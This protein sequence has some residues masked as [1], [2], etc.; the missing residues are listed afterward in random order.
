LPPR[1]WACGVRRLVRGSGL[2]KILIRARLLV[3]TPD[4]LLDLDCKY[5]KLRALA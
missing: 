1:Y 2:E 5:A 3:R 4:Y